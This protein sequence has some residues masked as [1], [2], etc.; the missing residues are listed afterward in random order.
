MYILEY[1][2]GETF[3]WRVIHDLNNYRLNPK[4]IKKAQNL[5]IYRQGETQS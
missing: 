1:S 5:R 3:V 2:V 4:L